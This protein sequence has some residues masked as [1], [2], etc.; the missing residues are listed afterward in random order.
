MNEILPETAEKNI[1]SRKGRKEKPFYFLNYL[2][3]ATEYAVM[4]K[5]IYKKFKKF[6][7]A[8]FAS[9]AAENNVFKKTVQP[10]F[11]PGHLPA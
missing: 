11:H 6:F 5:V 8:P 10:V 1:F 4:H 3:P 7:F 2:H 9:F